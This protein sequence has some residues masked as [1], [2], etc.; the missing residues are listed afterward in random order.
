MELILSGKEID[1][2]R[3]NNVIGDHEIA[4]RV[5]DVIIAENLITR[6]RRVITVDASRFLNEANKRILKG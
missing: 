6:Q 4:I 3:S 2:L 1:S 5:G